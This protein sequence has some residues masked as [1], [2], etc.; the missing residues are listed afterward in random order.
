MFLYF[1]PSYFQTAGQGVRIRHVGSG[2]EAGHMVVVDEEGG[3]WS[4]GNNDHGQLG[5][6][7]K[8]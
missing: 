2:P 8:R 6:G 4:W 7:D 5:Q 1:F 3:A